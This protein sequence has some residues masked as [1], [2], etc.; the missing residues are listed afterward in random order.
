[1]QGHIC[2]HRS[3][4][5]ILQSEPEF[6]AANFLHPSPLMDGLFT[7]S[8]S[9]QRIPAL[10]HVI[11]VAGGV[12]IRQPTA[13]NTIVPIVVTTDDSCHARDWGNGDTSLRLVVYFHIRI[14]Q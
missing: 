14:I 1:M 9:E 13:I 2:L 8:A 5:T 10:T 4:L 3:L 7:F 12:L 11:L 6:A